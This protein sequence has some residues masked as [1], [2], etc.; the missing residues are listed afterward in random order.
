MSTLL[1]KPSK[2]TSGLSLEFPGDKSISHRAIMF[3][4]IARGSATISRFLISQDTLCTLE[5]FRALGIDISLNKAKSRAVVQGKGLRGLT[6]P[7]KALYMGNSGTSMRLLL[8][9]LAGQPFETTLTGDESLSQRP[10][11][12]VIEPLSV[13]GAL[14]R[15]REENF[16]PLTIRGG[17]L[18]GIRYALP[19]ASAQVKSAVLLAGLYARGATIVEEAL[20]SRDHTERMLEFLGARLSRE[21]GYVKIEPGEFAARDIEVAGDFS[22]AAF[23]IVAALIAPKAKLTIASIGLNPTRSALL[24]VLSR[25]G[26]S[27]T[28]TRT[29]GDIGEPQGDIAV[30]SSA[31]QGTVV[32]AEEVPRLIDEIP[33][34]MIAATQ[35]RGRTVIQNAGELRFKE[36]DRIASMQEALRK[37]GEG[38]W[39]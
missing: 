38:A 26:G 30:K 9:I 6:Q 10:M 22:S 39:R 32:T 31:L 19:V 16:A 35:A 2:I 27:I 24:D 33:I 23:F 37:M 8:G 21:K 28:V 17:D 14:I 1:V 13:M 18:K 4:S 3:S 36:T 11:K 5:A 7:S 12:R 15:A 29:R 20:R 34:L 25:M